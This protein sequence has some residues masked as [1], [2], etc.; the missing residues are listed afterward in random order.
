MKKQN[1]ELQER[2]AANGNLTSKEQNELDRLRKFSANNIRPIRRV[3]SLNEMLEHLRSS[4]N[5][6]CRRLRYA[7][8]AKEDQAEMDIVR[9]YRDIMLKLQSG[10][11][12]NSKQVCDMMEQKLIAEAYN[13]DDT[14]SIVVYRDASVNFSTRF[15][16]LDFSSLVPKPGLVAMVV[17]RGQGN[18]VRPN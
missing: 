7:D 10:E 16:M 12:S 17:M 8:K 18:I 2:V 14:W 13:D 3:P 4:E 15:L 1:D 9:F 6:D 5:T 11:I